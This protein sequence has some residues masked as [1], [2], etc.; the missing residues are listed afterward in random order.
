M[1]GQRVKAF[2]SDLGRMG[3]RAEGIEKRGVVRA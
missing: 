1:L 2:S 3:H